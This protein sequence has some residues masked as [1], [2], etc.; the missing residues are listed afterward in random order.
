L[1]I[2]VNLSDHVPALNT[3]AN[4]RPVAVRAAGIAAQGVAASVLSGLEAASGLVPSLLPGMVPGGVAARV[5]GADLPTLAADP[6]AVR[7]SPGTGSLGTIPED[8]FESSLPTKGISAAD[9]IEPDRGV[10]LDQTDV[11]KGTSGAP[12]IEPESAAP[13]QPAESIHANLKVSPWSDEG[14]DIGAAVPARQLNPYQV[15]AGIVRG[16]PWT[17]ATT[18][19]ALAGVVAG[20]VVEK[21]AP[22]WRRPDG[23]GAK[24]DDQLMKEIPL[25]FGQVPVEPQPAPMRLRFVAVVL[26]GALILGA[27]AVSVL[28]ATLGLKDLPGFEEM[29]VGAASLLIILGVLYQVVFLTLGEATPGMKCARVA[30]CTFD[31]HKTTRAQRRLRLGALILSLLPAGLG[32]LWTILDRNHLSVHDRMSRTYLRKY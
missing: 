11:T 1:S 17:A 3:A 7:V 29:A 22:D 26:D 23:A 24:L 27:I 2:S 8:W 28:V 25:L 30:L 12:R 20:A 10:A 19:G 32:V 5:R 9:R 6:A 21:A 31:G 13:A 15:D 4:P 18:A 14:P 16:Q